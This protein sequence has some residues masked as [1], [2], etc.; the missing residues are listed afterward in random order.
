MTIS[1]GDAAVAAKSFPRRWREL[2]AMAAADEDHP[3][4]L[5]RSGAVGMA[6]EAATLLA[7]TAERLP[8]SR[9]P[10]DTEGGGP[11][12]RLES[13]AAALTGTIDGVPA[14]DWGRGGAL[15]L[16]EAGIDGAA[17]LLRQAETAIEDARRE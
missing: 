17:A 2:F 15:E 10:A 16:L 13:A 5:E 11:L 8:A 9:V 4:L 3:D 12:D 1:P 7:E 14:D 6:D